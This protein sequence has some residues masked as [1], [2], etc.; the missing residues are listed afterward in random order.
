VSA[1]LLLALALLSIASLGGSA[2]VF[3]GFPRLSTGLFQRAAGPQAGAPDRIRLGGTG[4]I[5]DDPFPV[6]RVRFDREPGEVYWRTGVFEGWTGAEWRRVP[7]PAAPVPAAGPTYRLAFPGA[8]ARERAADVELLAPEGSVPAPGRPLAVT[9]ARRP[10]QPAPGLGLR[11]DGSLEL[12]GGGGEVRYRIAVVGEGEPVREVLPRPDGPVDAAG[13][14]E[15]A[16]AALQVP[17]DVDPRV[18][19]LAATFAAAGGPRDIAEAI[20][21]YL[22]AFRY[23][24]ELPGDAAADP[25]ARFLFETRAGHCEFFASALASLLRL[26][27]VPA[28]VVSGFYGA[29][30]VQGA[31]Y[32]LVRRGDAHAWTEAYLPGEGWTRFDAT[33]AADRPG[34][35]SSV[36]AHVIEGVDVLRAR[37]ARWVLDYGGEDQVRAVTAV[38]TA[39]SGTGRETGS[40]ARL[41]R[42]LVAGLAV[43]GAMLLWPRFR[44]RLH[45]GEEA[46]GPEARAAVAFYRAVKRELHRRGIAL[47]RAATAEEWA[48]AAARRDPALGA[49][50]A[51]AL[52]AY[53]RARFGGRALPPATARR[54]L[55]GVR[56]AGRAA[57]R[58]A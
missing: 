38:L 23:T 39:L 34:D 20:E 9:F 49:A 35:A 36:W 52:E 42:W 17:A 33:P 10:G 3:V 22:A 45:A 7:S 46:P 16:R 11:A 37:W 51:T 8:G 28:R 30:R 1:A 26:N 24:R 25:L 40:L 55:A 19:E 4:F 32:W 15:D 12:R 21:R 58:A 6:M 2:L 43:G 47:S 14:P 56:A 31:D 50:A 57:A 54:L 27:G 41:A 5:K 44:R 29:A 53:G 18:R 13:Y 48:R